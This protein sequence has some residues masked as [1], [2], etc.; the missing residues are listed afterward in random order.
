MQHLQC[1][2]SDG[3]SHRDTANASCHASSF[4]R[5]ARSSCRSRRVRRASAVIPRSR[6]S[7]GL[8]WR[9]S[10]C[11]GGLVAIWLCRSGRRRASHV[12]GW[13]CPVTD[14]VGRPASRRSMWMPLIWAP[15]TGRVS[16]VR[17]P[18]WIGDAK[19]GGILVLAGSIIDQLDSVTFVFLR[20]LKTPVGRPFVCTGVFDAFGNC[21]LWNGI[22][23]RSLQE[24]E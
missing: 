12:T 15:D 20:R 3:C 5:V 23:G 1:E 8:S 2:S 11:G 4:I 6:R 17:V 14:R 21:I 10:D 7:R 16:H 19:L 18:V 9:H 24:E 22:V 13:R